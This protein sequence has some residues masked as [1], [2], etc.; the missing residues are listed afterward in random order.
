MTKKNGRPTMFRLMAQCPDCGKPH[1][2]LASGPADDIVQAIC[3]A[4]KLIERSEVDADRFIIAT[5][6][7][8]DYSKVAILRLGEKTVETDWFINCPRSL[9]L[10]KMKAVPEERFIISC[11][12]KGAMFNHNLTDMAKKARAKGKNISNFLRHRLSPF[13]KGEK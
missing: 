6:N 1:L 11:N 2:N 9:C 3:I 10:K 13:R 7:E 4:I 12:R 8:W 5:R